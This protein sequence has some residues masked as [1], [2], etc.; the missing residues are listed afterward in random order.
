[1]Q[2]QTRILRRFFTPSEWDLLTGNDEFLKA[3]DAAGSA[4]DL[5]SLLEYAIRWLRQR[6]TNGSTPSESSSGDPLDVKK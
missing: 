2:I 1:V 4:D 5:E 3:A 6:E